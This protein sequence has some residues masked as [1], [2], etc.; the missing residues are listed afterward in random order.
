MG[1]GILFLGYLV[2][3]VLT[4]VLNSLG[5]GFL[6]YLLGI[7][8]MFSGIYRLSR[9]QNT[10][11]YS[12]VA[13]GFM[14]LPNALRAVSEISKL[15]GVQIKDFGEAAAWTFFFV[16]VVFQAM[17]LYAIGQIAKET[18]LK[19][20]RASAYRNGIFVLIYAVTYV[21]SKILPVSAAIYFR[22][23]VLVFEVVLI[24]C[25]LLL[26]LTCAK[27]ICPAGEEE[28]LPKDS[29]IAFLNV[30]RDTMDSN[31][32]K[33]IDK[34]SRESEDKLKNQRKRKK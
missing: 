24:L 21:L 14:L 1:F 30:M 9:Y 11:R 8:L 13:L 2:T 19:A 16:S 29:K 31:W 5:V 32:E 7:V 34:L 15:M 17:M 22:L 27:D 28:I 25:N 20:I 18:D 6:G 23:P 33:A 26:I 10:F 12:M 3:Y 4:L